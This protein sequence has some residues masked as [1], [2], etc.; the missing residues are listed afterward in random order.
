MMLSMEY[1]QLGGSGLKVPVL[2]FGTVT[3]GGSG[4]RA[5]GNTDVAE[6]TRLVDIALEAGI[7]FFD[8]AD[9]Y[10]SGRSEEILGQAMGKRR[11]EI[12]LATKATFRSEPG[13]NGLGS[14][15]H[16]L[17]RSCEA[18]LRRLQSDH[19][20]LY[21]VHRWD[22][23]TR[24]DETLRALDDLVRLGKVRYLGVSAFAAWQLAHA[25]VLAE[26]R[27]WT[28]FVA[29]QSEYNMLVRDVEDEVLPYCRAY[30][31][32]FVPYYPL[33]GGFLTGK[34]RPGEPPP[35]GSRGSPGCSD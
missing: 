17:L 14:S 22:P 26:L 20:D 24:I 23:T 2:A 10:N 4:E 11:D 15:R 28:P 13:P 1:R 34:Y 31:V 19:L 5:W 30:D 16:H 32:G 35:P 6:A 33:A 9:V 18:S 12:L 25:N 21:Y 8:T 29:I 7:N 27:G 3:F